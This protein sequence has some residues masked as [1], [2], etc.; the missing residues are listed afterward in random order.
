MK[1]IVM[2][3]MLAAL[4]GVAGVAWA[5]RG[6]QGPEGRGG[7]EQ[8]MEGKRMMRPGNPEAMGG[9]MIK[10]LLK[11]PDKAAEFGITPEQAK[12]LQASFYESE[13]KMVGLRA[14]V[15]SAEIEVRELMDQDSPDEAAMMAAIDKAGQARTAIQKANAQQRLAVG[16]IVSPETMKKIRERVEDRMR[17]SKGAGEK[18][19]RGGKD[20]PWKKGPMEGPGVE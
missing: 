1:R 7:Q 20:A 19:E 11:N 16:K 14:A 8:G 2:T 4:I 17:M 18:G 12:A 3:S 5:E 10:Q 15:D 13:K 9:H 6:E